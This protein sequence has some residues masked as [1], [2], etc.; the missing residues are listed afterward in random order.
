MSSEQPPQAQPVDVSQQAPPVDVQQQQQQQQQPIQAVE[1]PEIK[2]A[3]AVEGGREISKKTLHVF[4]LPQTVTEDMLREL[5]SVT[6]NV[7]SIKILFDKNKPGFNYA[8]IEYDNTQSAEM[9]KHTLNG[10]AINNHEITINWAFQ[11]QTNK[12]ENLFNLFVGD[13]SSDVND[14][15]LHKAFARFQSLVSAHVMWDMQTGRSRSYGFVSFADQGDAELALNTMKNEWISGR[16]IRLNWASHKQLRGTNLGHNN[17]MYMQKNMN[18]GQMAMNN[19]NMNGN[20]NN[21]NSIPMGLNPVQT[22]DYVLRQT[23]NWQTTVYIGNIAHFTSQND[24]IPLLQTYGFIVNF[25]FHPEKGCAFVKYDSH[26]RATIAIVQ[27]NGYNF[28]GRVLKSGWGKDT[29]PPPN[30]QYQNFRGV[31]GQQH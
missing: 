26:D 5:F 29:R 30:M 21:N 14:E 10:R 24:L 18:N 3:N 27:L 15:L 20:N 9:A 1:I 7:N 28:N 2:P 17:N 8:F 23:P 13:L 25:K 6:G 19:L 31:Y 22:Y 4:G 12:S 11:S 16:Q